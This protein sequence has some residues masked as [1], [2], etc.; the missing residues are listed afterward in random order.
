MNHDTLNAQRWLKAAITLGASETTRIPVAPHRV[1][2]RAAA[3]RT[4][5]THT[6]EGK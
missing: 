3:A 5:L 6:K 4:V 2:G 1:L